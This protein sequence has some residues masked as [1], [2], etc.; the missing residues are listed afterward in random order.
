MTKRLEFK[1]NHPLRPYIAR[2]K[3]NMWSSPVTQ[4]H[5]SQNGLRA[6]LKELQ[7]EP[8]TKKQKI[9]LSVLIVRA[10]EERPH[11]TSKTGTALYHPARRSD[12]SNF[13]K[14]IEDAIQPR[15]QDEWHLIPNDAQIWRYGRCEKREGTRDLIHIVL[16]EIE[17]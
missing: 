7:L 9:K 17:R 1:L 2:N 8:F 3:L 15:K 4:Y 16:E 13:V 14:A 12:L 11:A 5:A 6:L 10:P